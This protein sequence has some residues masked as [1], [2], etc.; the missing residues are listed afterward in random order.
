MRETRRVSKAEICKLNADLGV[1]QSNVVGLL[2]GIGLI[3]GFGA[4]AAPFLFDV[5][6]AETAYGKVLAM[7]YVSNERGVF[8]RA[9][10]QVGEQRVNIRLSRGDPCRVGDRIEVIRHKVLVG[11]RFTLG[12]HG[13]TRG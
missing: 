1:H 10:V 6:P 7:A 12:Y 5:G 13:C 2:L 4:L 3:V 9:V 11:K 8:P